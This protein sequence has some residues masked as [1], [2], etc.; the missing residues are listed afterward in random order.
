M[1]FLRTFAFHPVSTNKKFTYCG[2]TCAT[3][4]ERSPKHASMVGTMLNGVQVSN[5]APAI[6]SKPYLESGVSG[7]DKL[8]PGL[9]S[10][11][12]NNR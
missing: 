12:P 3:N 5:A 2:D 6:P 4:L 9:T 8:E 11:Y 7:S 10:A 1:S